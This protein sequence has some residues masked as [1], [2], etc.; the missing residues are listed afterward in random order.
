MYLCTAPVKVVMCQRSTPAGCLHRRWYLQECIICLIVFWWTWEEQ[1]SVSSERTAVHSLFPSLWF[2]FML[3]NYVCVIFHSSAGCFV[4]IY[5]DCFP[6]DRSVA[7]IYSI[8]PS[9]QADLTVFFVFVFPPSYYHSLP[10]FS[11]YSLSLSL[12]LGVFINTPPPLFSLFKDGEYGNSRNPTFLW[13]LETPSFLNDV[14]F[15]S[16]QAMQCF[17]LVCVNW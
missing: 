3:E 2:W 15:F 9:I 1:S 8:P 7:I 5:H 16:P 17:L 11:I 12:H 10:L 6:L 14:L 4:R 13:I